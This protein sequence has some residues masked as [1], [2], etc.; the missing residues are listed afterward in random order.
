MARLDQMD[1]GGFGRLTAR[2]EVRI[3]RVLPGPRERVWRY[4]TEADLRRQWLAAGDFDLATG[5]AIELVFRN[6][7]LT[8]GDDPPPAHLAAH[9]EETRL[10]GTVLAC[11]PPALLAFTWGTGPDASSVRFDLAEEGKDVRLTV[12]HSR[13]RDRGMTVLVST[14]WHV[15]LDIL[16]DRL[17]GRTPDGFWRRVGALQP[18]YDARTP[19]A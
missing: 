2:D 8:E 13:T 11:E 1:D 7:D 3:E 19:A 14:G 17:A 12:T 10:G 5:G 15:H 6:N 4:L 9:G 18:V 16:A